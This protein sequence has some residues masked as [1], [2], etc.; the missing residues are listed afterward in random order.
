MNGINK[1]GQYKVKNKI[2]KEL[3]NYT[4]DNVRNRIS[5]HSEK[6]ERSRS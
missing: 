6:K 2:R 3:H 4:A 1:C 5:R